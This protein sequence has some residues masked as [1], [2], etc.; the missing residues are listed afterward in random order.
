MWNTLYLSPP[1]YQVTFG[2]GQSLSVLFARVVLE[3]YVPRRQRVDDLG[4]GQDEP[5][6]P[7]LGH[8]AAALRGALGEVA[9]EDHL[10]PPAGHLLIISMEVMFF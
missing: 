1:C 10:S 8:G 7:P 9:G 2:V 4:V 5:A 3:A 6:P